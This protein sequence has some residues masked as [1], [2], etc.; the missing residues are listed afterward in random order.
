MASCHMHVPQE[1]MRVLEF[2]KEYDALGFMDVI[3]D[4]GAQN[5]V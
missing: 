4:K 2:L 1:M 5:L 3:R